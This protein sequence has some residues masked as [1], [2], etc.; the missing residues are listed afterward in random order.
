MITVISAPAFGNASASS[1][2]SRDGQPACTVCRCWSVTRCLPRLTRLGGSTRRN[3]RCRRRHCPGL[4]R[5][6]RRERIHSPQTTRAAD[7]ATC[8]EAVERQPLPYL[9]NG[10]NFP[11][12][13]LC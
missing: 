6:N 3:R 2:K 9:C 10:V 11:E 12:K 1:A 13:Q 8:S 7:L 5:Q 4:H